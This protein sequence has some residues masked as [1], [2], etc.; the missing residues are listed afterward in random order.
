MNWMSWNRCDKVWSSANSLLKWCFRNCHRCFCLSSLMIL[1]EVDFPG[2]LPIGQVSFKSYLPSKKI[3]LPV[4]CYQTGP[5]FEPW[6]VFAHGVVTLR[7][8]SICQN[9]PAGPLLYQSVWKW[10]RRFPRVF[11]EKPYPSCIL[12]RIGLIWLEGFEI[13]I[14]CDGNGLACQFWQIESTLIN[15]FGIENGTHLN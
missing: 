5:F 6:E 2:P 9:W 10:S 11:A 13:I 12:F 7:A 1:F 3:S 8:L 14:N 4:P 15:F